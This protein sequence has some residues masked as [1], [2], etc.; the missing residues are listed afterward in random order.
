MPFGLTNTP[1]IFMDYMNRIFSPFLDRFVVVFIDDILIYSKTSQEHETHL[2]LVL[3]ILREKKLYANLKKCEFWLTMVK[4]LGHV[5]S[6][7]GILVDPH[8]VETVLNWERPRSIIKI[9]SFLSLAGYYK[10]FIQGFSQ[11]ATPLN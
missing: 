1:A 7:E 8:K 9:R 2:R 10:R 11:I 4:F 3:Q 6:K 5:M